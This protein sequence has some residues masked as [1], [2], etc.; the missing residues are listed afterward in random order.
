LRA[1]SIIRR[2][3]DGQ[4]EVSDRLGK[5]LSELAERVRTGFD[6]FSDRL[7]QEQE[8]L[9]GV[10]SDKLEDIRTGNEAKLEQM[11][12]AVD[13]QLQWALE[14]RLEESFQRVTEQFARV[15][16]A[17]GQVQSVAGQAR[18]SHPPAWA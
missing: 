2:P 15:Q 18:G 3:S 11:R 13:E 1:I 8:L 7:R 16:Q 9:R 6:G 4:K 5:E 10:V 12:K 17:I 14:K